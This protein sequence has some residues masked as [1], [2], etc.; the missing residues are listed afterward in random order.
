MK[1]V[2]FILLALVWLLFAMVLPALPLSASAAQ[3]NVVQ[4]NKIIPYKP[5][6]K[7]SDLAGVPDSVQVELSP[8]RQIS[9][10][11][12][13]RLEILQQK[14]QAPKISR[15]PAALRIKPSPTGGR[16]L[17]SV[18]ELPSL[19][20]LPDRETIVLPSGHRATVAQIKFLQPFV[21][22]QTGISFNALPKRP[23]LQGT[24]VQINARSDWQAILQ[25]PDSTILESPNGRRITVA[26]AK[27]YLIQH[28]NAL[29][30]DKTTPGTSIKQQN[31][32]K[33]GGQ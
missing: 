9:V 25:M 11:Q 31:S 15:L 27:Q 26:E 12:L 33:G 16:R 29:P 3:G 24:A 22:K 18:S 2:R 17:Y 10:A 5:Q 23:N 4:M 21:E 6:L 7:M 32:R 1:T 28:P 30:V 13:R 8:G 19:L 20:K 14:M